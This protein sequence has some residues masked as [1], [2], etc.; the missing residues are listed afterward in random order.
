[1]RPSPTWR[2]TAAPTLVL[3][4]GLALTG[5]SGDTPAASGDRSSD[6][7]STTPTSPAIGAATSAPSEPEPPATSVPPSET[8]SGPDPVCGGLTLDVVRDVLGPQTRSYLAEVD[9][10]IFA[11][12][13][14]QP[15]TLIVSAIPTLGDPAE[16]AQQARDFCASDVTDVPD[17]GDTAWVCLSPAAGPQGVVVADDAFVE[18]DLTSGDDQADLASLLELVLYVEVPTGLEIPE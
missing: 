4:L 3:A 7:P 14:H 10:C 16:F 1:M 11:A 9:Y 6:E 18:L 8:Q 15:P 5:C 17:V 12:P 13:R 2:R